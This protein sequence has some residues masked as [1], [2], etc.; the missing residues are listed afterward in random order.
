MSIAAMNRLCEEKG[1]DGY[2]WCYEDNYF[3]KRKFKLFYNPVTNFQFVCLSFGSIKSN[4][5]QCY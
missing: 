2:L 4:C 3:P 1:N 5:T